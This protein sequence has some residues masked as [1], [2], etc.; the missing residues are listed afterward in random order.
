MYIYYCVYCN[1]FES[2]D[3]K[4][5]QHKCPN[6]NRMLLPLKVS[7]EKWNDLSDA[8]MLDR[9]DRARKSQGNKK[10]G[11]QTASKF[12]SPKAIAIAAIIV[13]AL[14]IALIVIKKKIVDEPINTTIMWTESYLDSL[15]GLKDDSQSDRAAQDYSEY[16]DAKLRGIQ[17]NYENL[18][19]SNKEKYEEWLWNEYGVTY[20]SL[21]SL[22]YY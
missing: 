10:D 19:S 13:A 7:I 21:S 15:S 2:F 20:N 16:V 14:A 22:R 12:I 9:I 4:K 1:D 17:S 5:G 11:K 8:E 6:C 3:D 18:S